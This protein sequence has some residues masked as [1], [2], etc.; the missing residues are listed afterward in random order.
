[1]KFRH[2]AAALL[3]LCCLTAC[4]SSQVDEEIYNCGESVIRA[5]DAYMDNKA[6]YD[7]TNKK[8]EG[9]YKQVETWCDEHSDAENQAYN[10]AV[11]IQINS[12]DFE[13]YKESLGDSTYADVLE[14][15]NK[16]A[17]EI[18]YPTRD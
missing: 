3:A 6:T 2:I 4:K 15:R 9:L 5:V 18:G 13:L 7:E 1:M 10:F 16:L 8:I 17:E 11:R 14:K 12:L